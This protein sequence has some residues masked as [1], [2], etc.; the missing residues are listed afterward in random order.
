MQSALEKGEF[1]PFYQPKINVV[2]GDLVGAEA[3][4]RWRHPE[5]GLLP[6]SSFV[7]FY[8]KNGFIVKIDFAMF[9]AACKQLRDWSRRGIAVVPIS[10]NFSRKHMLDKQFADKLREI[11]NR[12]EVAPQLLEVEI[13]ETIELESMDTAV[14]FAQSLKA[15]GFTVSID[16]YGTGYSSI[17]FCKSYR[18]MCSSWIKFFGQRHGDAESQGYHAPCDYRGKGQ[19]HP[20]ALR[21]NRDGSPAGFC[22]GFK[23]SI[24]AG[25]FVLQAFARRRV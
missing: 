18:S 11:A 15:N 2:T 12:Y 8:E 25:V 24:C 1:E 5:E 19:W 4:V 20:S 21:G 13:T 16:D 10:V 14:E 3:L 22:L 6:P 17:A 9:E 23:L 7:P